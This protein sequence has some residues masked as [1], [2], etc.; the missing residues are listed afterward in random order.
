MQGIGKD[1]QSPFVELATSTQGILQDGREIVM[2]LTCRNKPKNV[3]CV[4]ECFLK[5][6]DLFRVVQVATWC[7]C[8]CTSYMATTGITEYL[9][10]GQPHAEY[11]GQYWI[12]CLYRILSP[13][14]DPL[15]FAITATQLNV[16]NT[17]DEKAVIIVKKIRITQDFLINQACCFCADIIH[18]TVK[19]IK[20]CSYKH[21]RYRFITVIITDQS[22]RSSSSSVRSK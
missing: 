15:D 20:T 5:A 21:Q 8:Q 18:F 17:I 14:N 12:S 1:W 6:Q 9:W 2:R 19:N 22:P 11:E 3:S 16:S 4:L 7:N 10:L 13:T